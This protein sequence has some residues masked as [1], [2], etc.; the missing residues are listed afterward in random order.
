MKLK[1]SREVAL[2]GRA[3]V[4]SLLNNKNGGQI[5]G[6]SAQGAS[7]YDQRNFRSYDKY[8]VTMA[9]ISFGM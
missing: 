3:E 4:G 7:V 9:G 8:W 5:W 2:I 1:L 6:P